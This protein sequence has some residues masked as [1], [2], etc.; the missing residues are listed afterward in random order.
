MRK[1]EA[2]FCLKTVYDSFPVNV[3]TFDNS[4]INGYRVII[5]IDSELDRKTVKKIAEQLNLTIKTSGSDLIL[6]KS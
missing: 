4:K 1:E 5:N 2:V 3:V 6:C